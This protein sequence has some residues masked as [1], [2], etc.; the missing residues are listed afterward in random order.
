MN[1]PLGNEE[2]RQ[3]QTTRKESKLG[4]ALQGVTQP[5]SHRRLTVGE[6][7]YRRQVSRGHCTFV[8]QAAVYLGVDSKLSS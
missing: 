3:T 4:G 1:P 7:P 8:T 5:W 6:I 2:R